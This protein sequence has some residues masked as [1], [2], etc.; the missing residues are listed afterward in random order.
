M[1]PEPGCLT[2]PGA[3]GAR[4][5]SGRER[6]NIDSDGRRPAVSLARAAF[7]CAVA[8]PLHARDS[9]AKRFRDQEPHRAQATT[10][11]AP[12]LN[13]RVRWAAPCCC[14]TGAARRA[15]G[16]PRH[17]PL[18]GTPAVRQHEEHRQR[19]P[20]RTQSCPTARWPRAGP[21]GSLTRPRGTRSQST[22][23]SASTG[24]TRAARSRASVA[25]QSAAGEGGGA[26]RR[27]ELARRSA[28]LFPWAAKSCQLPSPR[29]HA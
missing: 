29:S 8:A 7:P 20:T 22:S 2:A 17:C 26:S 3:P 6:P 1:Y 19:L 4:A 9:A 18:P 27:P 23:M 5:L 14:A 16:G 21:V 28:K 15:A 25:A 24:R 13:S 12:M 11:W 10:S